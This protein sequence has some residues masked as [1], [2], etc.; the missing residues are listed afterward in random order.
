MVRAFLFLF[1]HLKKRK[2]FYFIFFSSKLNR[3]I[4]NQTRNR[5]REREREKEKET[6]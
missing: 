5:N 3:K 4:S 1:T 2:G 6:N